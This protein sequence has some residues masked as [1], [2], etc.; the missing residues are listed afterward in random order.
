MSHE[1]RDIHPAHGGSFE[2]EV[3]RLSAPSVHPPL[4]LVPGVGG[5]RGTFHHQ[6]RA[7]AENRDVIATNLNAS[8]APASEPVDSAAH[9]VLAVLDALGLERVDLLGS[10]FGS[11]AVARL[12]VLAPRRVRRMVW[13]AP[14]VLHHGPWRRAFGPGWLIGGALMK[15]AP[16]GYREEV[17]RVLATRRVYSPEPDLSEAE[18]NLLAGRVSDTQLAPFFRRLSGLRDWDWRRLPAP[19]AH[20]ALVI[21]GAK[22][23]ALT[24]LDV[25][26]AWERLTGRP[27][28]VTAGTHMPYLSFPEEFNHAVQAFLDEPEGAS[29]PPL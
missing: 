6:V 3:R 7:F 12:A 17:I 26:R 24:P 29:P 21:Q 23:H 28:V 14:P 4:V 9:D 25:R 16:P 19:A 2:I 20:P 27:V 11:C 1:V 10:S 13:V 5:P 15:Y 22:E 8:Q 18:L